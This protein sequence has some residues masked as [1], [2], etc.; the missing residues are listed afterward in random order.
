MQLVVRFYLDKGWIEVIELLI[1]VDVQFIYVVL[2]YV[3][4][5]GLKIFVDIVC[6]KDKFGGCIY[7]IELGS[8]LNCIIWKMIDDNCFG[9]KGFQLVEF[10]EV[11]MFMVVK[12]V[13]KCKQWVVFFGWK[14]YL[15]NLQIDMIYFIGSEDVFGFDE[16]VVIVFIMIVV[17]Y[18]VQCG[19]VVWLL[20]NLCFS[21]VQVSQVMVLIFDCIQFFDVVWQ[22]LKVNFELL[23]VWLDGVSIFDGKDG[24][25]VFQVLLK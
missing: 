8:G 1:L 11:G 14:L 15:M 2:S 7:V 24:L 25:V 19:N 17:G 21:S 5:G 20:Y 18:Q 6:F 3:V 16:G 10:S 23:K 22:W 9:L 13:I 4:E 12:W